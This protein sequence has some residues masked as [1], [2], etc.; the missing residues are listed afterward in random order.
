MFTKID[1]RVLTILLVILV[2]ILLIGFF[3]VKSIIAPV[4]QVENVT[5]GAKIE[6]PAET[7][8]NS[9]NPPAKPTEDKKPA[10][11]GTVEATFSICR[12]S[13]GDGFCQ[14]TDPDCGK[15]EQNCICIENKTECPQDCK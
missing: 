10:D 8:A 4:G 7:P 9:E 12:D 13:C 15:G 2:A 1:K 14:L 5:G 3:L 11:N 6:N